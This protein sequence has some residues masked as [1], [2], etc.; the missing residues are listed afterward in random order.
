MVGK[1]VPKKGF[2]GRQGGRWVVTPHLRL[3]VLS[4]AK[5]PQTE[6]GSEKGPL[7]GFKIR[8]TVC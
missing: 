3:I 8:N 7:R 1:E 5:F 2:G 4:L 6:V